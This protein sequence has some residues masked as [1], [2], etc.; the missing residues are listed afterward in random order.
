M[1]SWPFLKSNE[2][3][4]AS[5]DIFRLKRWGGK[6]LIGEMGLKG[7]DFKGLFDNIFSY[8]MRCAIWYHL[9]NFKNVKTTHGGVFF[10]VKLHA[11]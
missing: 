7:R 1:D 10:L 9:Y 8:A 3:G 4:G 2:M 11:K 6:Q 5:S